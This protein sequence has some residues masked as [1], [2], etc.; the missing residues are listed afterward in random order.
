MMS[1]P[2]MWLAVVL[3]GVLN[4]LL[5][6]WVVGARRHRAPLLLPAAM[7]VVG[8]LEA[9][10]GMA[11]SGHGVFNWYLTVGALGCIALRPRWMRASAPSGARPDA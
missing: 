11:L 5:C 3:G 1:S 8:P 7:I 10:L 9:G 2:P 4:P 6:W